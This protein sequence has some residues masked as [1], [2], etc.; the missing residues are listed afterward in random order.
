MAEITAAQAPHALGAALD[1][2]WHTPLDPPG[3][4]TALIRGGTTAGGVPAL[5]P[6]VHHRGRHLD[7]PLERT[8]SEIQT[9]LLRL[10]ASMPLKHLRIDV[11][12]PRVEGRL[13]MFAPLRSAH[14]ASFPPASTSTSAFREV[15]ESATATAAANAEVIAT[16]HASDLGDLWKRRGVPTGQYRVV[17]VL[18]YPEGIDRETQHLL[19]RLARSGGRGGVILIVQNDEQGCPVDEE[20]RAADLADLL[21]KSRVDASGD[22]LLNGYPA[23][24]VVRA[25]GP[26][27]P[28][29]VSS[30]IAAAAE[31]ASSDTGPVV[32]LAD[33][34]ASDVENPWT[35]DG[36]DELEAVIARIGERDLSITLRSQNPPF[37]NVLV[38][39]A[40]GQGKSNLLLDIVYALAARYSPDD[41]ELHLLDFK[42]GLEFQRFAADAAGKNWLPHAAVLSLESDRAFGVAVLR[43]VAEELEERAKK[44][45]AHGASGIEDYRRSTGQ[46]MPRLLLI[47]DEFQVLFDGDDPLTDEA[48]ALLE[49]L[50]RQG[51]ASGV[52]LL[53]SSQ[54]TSGVTGL[55]VKGESIFAQF[56]VRISLKNTVMESEAI[57][58]Q[59]NKAAADLTYRGEIIVNRNTG[60]DPEHSNE[61]AISAYA[62]PGFVADLQAKL[63]RLRPEGKGP[64]VFVSTEFARW[65]QMLPAP[66][67]GSS[68]TGLIGR[69]LEV[70]E[71]PVAL[72]LDDDVDQTV[73]VVGSDET[74]ALPVIS[75]LSQTIGASFAPGEV[76][77]IDL[78]APT[79]A[80]AGQVIRAE[81]CEL[82]EAGAE[83][84]VVGRDEATSTMI[85]AVRAALADPGR[86]MLVLGLG[87]QRWVGLDDPHPARPDDDDDFSTV[88]VRE[89]L[90]ELT[91]RGGVQGVHLVA[92]WTTLRSLQDQLGYSYSGVRHFIT[93]KLG[94]EDYRGLTSHSEQPITGYPRVA[95]I[96]RG[97]DDGPTVVIPFARRKESL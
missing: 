55:R 32:P 77:V 23:D 70:S 4:P 25:D 17:V 59:G 81:L 76:I 7:G 16:E 50:S 86:R 39:G 78:A 47:V 13:G 1:E 62:E 92:W 85:G 52:H 18:N 87:W 29:L 33:L 54:T 51:R 19:T 36:I 84:T 82:A 6:L 66:E 38:G 34:I 94:L 67:P 91:Q 24:V 46:T 56:P 63:W 80:D 31:R 68:A 9:L 73:A 28:A 58:S 30:V 89:V 27:P 64:L 75:A 20:V 90:E 2:S 21:Y 11:F 14:S 40:V 26:P 97:G 8:T 37:A 60:H 35:G 44:F 5:Y 10:I 42:R 72:T 95:H 65:P 12:D 74:L 45:K 15:L 61:Q 71:R 53:L 22:L 49:T 96:D 3:A 57:L 69:P 79:S 41:V 43:H 88:C 48:V 83:L 93:A